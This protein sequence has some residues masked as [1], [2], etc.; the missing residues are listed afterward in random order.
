MSSKEIERALERAIAIQP[1]FDDARYKLALMQSNE[2]KYADAVHNLQLMKQPSGARAFP[3][4]VALSYALSELDKRDEA[5][6]AANQA[7]N[8]ASTPEDR[9][10]AAQLAYFAETDMTVRFAR[11]SKGNLQLVT[12]RVPHG[13]SD[14][15]PFIEPNDHIERVTGELKEVQ[16]SEGRLV[17]L[18]VKSEGS[19]TLSLAVPD[20]LHVMIKNGPSQF[21]CGPQPEKTVKVVYA[22]AAE[23]GNGLLRGLEFQ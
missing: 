2:G 17:G 13:T 3:Y 23:P 14:F 7:M 8:F 6:S 1:A 15:N 20:P 4:W 19:G 11:D 22:T 10:R 9:G 12:T 18:V 5:T 21:Y 16:C